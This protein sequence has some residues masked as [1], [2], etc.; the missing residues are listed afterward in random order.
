MQADITSLFGGG[1]SIGLFTQ[2]GEA[3]FENGHP[4]TYAGEETKIVDHALFDHHALS[5]IVRHEIA[6]KSGKVERVF[7]VNMHFLPHNCCKQD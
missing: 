2:Y 5:P 4:D 7:G 6:A 3:S 1:G